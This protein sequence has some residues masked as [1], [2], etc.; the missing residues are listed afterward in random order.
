MHVA[1]TGSTQRGAGCTEQVQQ[2]HREAQ[3]SAAQEAHS[4]RS[5]PA[6]HHSARRKRLD[7]GGPVKA[8]GAGRSSGRAAPGA[9]VGSGRRGVRP[10][11]RPLAPPEAPRC[12]AALSTVQLRALLQDEP[13]L[14]RAARLSRKVGARRGSE[15]AGSSVRG[16]GLGGPDPGSLWPGT[17]RPGVP[18]APPRS[19]G[20][21][22]SCSRLLRCR[23][24]RREGWG[25][26]HRTHRKPERGQSLCPCCSRC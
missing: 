6:A 22:C 7:P 23:C 4:G 25:S 24:C 26:S 9:A 8:D 13:R 15:A 10:M 3:C 5:M 12:F 11:A 17:G 16:A 1:G 2:T 19:R 18:A 20:K 21:L 14:Q